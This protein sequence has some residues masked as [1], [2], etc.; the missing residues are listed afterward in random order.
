MSLK[1]RVSDL[2]KITGVSPRNIRYYDSVGL[3][4]ASGVL[5]NGYRYYSI[6]KIEELRLISYLRHAGI[7][8][9]EIKQHLHSR[10]IDEYTSILENQLSKVDDEIEHLITLKKRLSK[11]ID[12]VNYI[13]NLPSLN[14]IIIEKL[15]PRAILQFDEKIEDPLDWEKA[16]LKFEKKGDLPPSLIIGESGFIVDL[17][18]WETRNPTEFTGVFMFTDD[19]YFKKNSDFVEFP[20]GYWLTLYI[21]GDHTAASNKYEKI[22]KYAKEHDLEL[23]DYAIERTLIDHFISSDPELYITEIQIPILNKN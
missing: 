20:P 2:S 12:S 16:M 7:S 17:T 10:D 3:F 1:L 18:K 22:M 19:P 5:D 23:A 11:R 4:D 13:R 15:P 14:K 8:I 9:K 21:K 6:D